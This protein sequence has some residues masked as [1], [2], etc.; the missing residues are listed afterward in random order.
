MNEQLLWRGHPS[1][2]V[3]FKIYLLCFLFFWLVIPIFI[4]FWKWLEVRCFIYELTNQRLKITTGIL[5]RRTEDLELCRVKDTSLEQPFWMRLFGA[6]NIHLHTTDKTT[7]LVIIHA[8]KNTENLRE[9]LRAAV[10]QARQE[11]GVRELDVE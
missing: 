4:A 11:K 9:Q 7:P 8:V 5:N 6:G 1:Q 2:L 3:N 10:E